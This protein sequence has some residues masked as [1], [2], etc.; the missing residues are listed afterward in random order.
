MKNSIVSPR[1]TQG[2]QE[3]LNIA[4]KTK[5]G[6]SE[7]ILNGFRSMYLNSLGEIKG[8][9]NSN[10]LF[11]IINAMND[12]ILDGVSIGTYVKLNSIDSIR[13]DKTNQEYNVDA[14]Q[15]KK[16]LK[17]LTHFQLCCLDIWASAIWVSS[18]HK[19]QETDINE[20]VKQLL[21]EE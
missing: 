15:F 9:F 13:F 11:L 19:E 3:C 7:L 20:Y 21:I 5:Q 1:I 6:G 4:F 8:K 10:E 16:K 2:T 14:K 12:T 17:K 18:Y